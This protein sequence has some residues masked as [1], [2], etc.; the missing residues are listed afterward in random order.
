MDKN[1]AS[2]IQIDGISDN[3]TEKAYLFEIG[4]EDVWIPKSQV[5]K[6][7]YALHRDKPEKALVMD[8]IIKSK[9]LEDYIVDSSNW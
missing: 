2:W 6:I 8:W 7:E 1:K 3:S 4:D 5:L 9:G